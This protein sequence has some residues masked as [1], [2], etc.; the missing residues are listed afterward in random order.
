LKLFG[1]KLL[2][3]W[4]DQNLNEVLTQFRKEQ[5][6][7]AF[8]RE[9]IVEDEEKDP[10]YKITGIIT[11]SDVM[12]EI[13]GT[14]L[15]KILLT[16]SEVDTI[17]NYLINCIS[18]LKLYL[19]ECNINLKEII[20]SS[21]VIIKKRQSTRDW[22]L[23]TPST[24]GTLV[25]PEDCIIQQGKFMNYCILILE[26]TVKMVYSNYYTTP[27]VTGNST[28]VTSPSSRSR[29]KSVPVGVTFDEIKL[30]KEW[31]LLCSDTL[32]SNENTFAPK[33]SAYIESKQLRYIKLRIPKSKKRGV[34]GTS[35]SKKEQFFQLFNELKHEQQH[36]NIPLPV[37]D[38]SPV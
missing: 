1:Q 27:R 20:R 2:V 37:A 14:S 22:T 13:F 36:Y 18:N 33:F 38:E 16:D 15:S 11:L 31:D 28:K 21:E 8:V 25:H 32:M 19:Y 35:R 12:Q 7:F 4:Y 6:E 17:Y 26:G 5:V 34:T 24:E 29:T 3:L 30:K 23:T 10:V 9:V